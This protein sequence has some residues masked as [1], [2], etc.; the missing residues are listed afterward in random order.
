MKH[1]KINAAEMGWDNANLPRAFF[2]N[3][4]IHAAKPFLFDKIKGEWVGQSWQEIE[5]K[6][7]RVASALLAFGVTP[8]TVLLLHLKIGL[9][10]RSVTSL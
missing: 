2:D 6:V 8:G 7:R 3:A 1:S 5:E 9:N 10:G 4:A